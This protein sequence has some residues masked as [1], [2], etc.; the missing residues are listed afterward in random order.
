MR[1]LRVFLIFP[2]CSFPV[3]GFNPLRQSNSIET[4]GLKSLLLS[5]RKWCV[6][7]AMPSAFLVSVLRQRVRASDNNPGSE[8]PAENH[9][10]RP[11]ILGL[12]SRRV[13]M[14]AGSGGVLAVARDRVCEAFRSGKAVA[15][16]G[17]CVAGAVYCLVPCFCLFVVSILD[18]WGFQCGREEK[19]RVE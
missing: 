8:F 1:G 10:K 9:K 5:R 14:G 18:G 6:P 7:A 2:R 17:E 19:G 12:D 16:V 11:S 3:E 4:R 13:R 15:G